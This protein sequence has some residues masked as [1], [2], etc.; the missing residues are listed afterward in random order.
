MKITIPTHLSDAAL[1]EEVTRLA[2]CGR[3][4]TAALVAHLAE[5]DE[6]ELYLGAGYR[7]L[8]AY[9][10]EVL[11]LSEHG[12]YNRI[13]AMRAARQF[14]VVLEMLRDGSLNL[15]TLRV[16]APHLTGENH[17]ALLSDAS[18]RSKRDVEAVV[19]RLFP[20]PDVPAL[21]RKLPVRGGPSPYCE[22]Q[23]T[24]IEMATTARAGVDPLISPGEGG[25]ADTPALPVPLT[26]MTSTGVRPTITALAPERYQIRFTASADTHAKLR[27]AQELLGHVVPRGDIG[28]VIDR[29]LTALLTDLR[30]KK[31]AA[32]DRP[33]HARIADAGSRHIPAHVRRAVWHRD[34]GQCA[35][36]AKSGVRCTARKAVEFHHVH[37]YAAGG[38][39]T[40]DNI[41]L[42]CRPHNGYEA[43]LFFGPSENPS[44]L[45]PGR[46][47]SQWHQAV[48]EHA[49]DL[50][51][52]GGRALSQDG[53]VTEPRSSPNGIP[54]AGGDRRQQ[55]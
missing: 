52:R 7:S 1:A 11:H 15:A 46:V 2:Q 50:K 3:E 4:T 49:R 27:E 43:G 16:L 47:R 25:A 10:T 53:N 26:A 9:C 44:E 41:Q 51:G 22:A 12:T 18:H 20:R 35:F 31:T 32:T 29:A 17:A 14:P 39:A 13:E 6:R 24:P 37:P 48:I 36:V 45:A 55:T 19:A 38:E 42:R 33:R 28:E 40:V 21:V 8:F 30:R 54:N 23:A 5:F 34:G